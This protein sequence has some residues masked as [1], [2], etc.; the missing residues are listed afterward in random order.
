[1]RRQ[2]VTTMY[3]NNSYWFMVSMHLLSYGCMW[4]VGKHESS[5][6]SNY[7]EQIA[8]CDPSSLSD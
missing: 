6:Q 5:I 4:E 2:M 8:K 3:N 7:H 1:M